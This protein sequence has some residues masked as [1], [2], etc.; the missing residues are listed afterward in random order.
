MSM[1]HT[2]LQSLSPSAK[3]VCVW[4]VRLHALKTHCE[5]E[6][7]QETIL[8]WAAKY[9]PFFGPRE[10]KII[11][12]QRPKNVRGTHLFSQI[13]SEVRLTVD[14]RTRCPRMSG[15]G[16]GRQNENTRHLKGTQNGWVLDGFVFNIMARAL[17]T[18]T[19]SQRLMS[20]SVCLTVCPIVPPLSV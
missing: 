11:K 5:R 12:T 1:S 4:H 17:H 20:L 7:E 14:C 15:G 8:R 2:I 9:P 13:S 3:Q 16:R 19:L 18:N 10:R 6:T